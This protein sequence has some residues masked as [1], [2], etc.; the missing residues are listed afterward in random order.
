M[1]NI[2][3]STRNYSGIAD[4]AYDRNEDAET[5]YETCEHCGGDGVIHYCGECDSDANICKCGVGQVLES[6]KCTHCDGEGE[7]EI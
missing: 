4:S 1:D 3:R 2:I 5:K 7:V 6:E